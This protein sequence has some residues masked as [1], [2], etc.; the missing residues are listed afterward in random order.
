MMLGSR[1]SE[2]CCSPKD[3]DGVGSYFEELFAYGSAQEMRNAGWGG[4]VE[5]MQFLDPGVAFPIFGDSI[6]GYFIEGGD[7]SRRT[8]IQPLVNATI[9][10]E[11]D[12][13][14]WGFSPGGAYFGFTV[15]R[16]VPDESSFDGHSATVIFVN[17]SP[18]QPQQAQIESLDF[19]LRLVAEFKREM[20]VGQVNNEQWTV[21]AW[22]NDQHAMV[23]YV[24]PYAANWVYPDRPSIT[25]RAECFT[26]KLFWQ[27]RYG[28]SM[29]RYLM[30]LTYD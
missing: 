20:V 1:C 16:G 25:E 23:N 4:A 29:S 22:V 6:P 17:D 13:D 27:G 30:R 14:S 18:N 7:L 26:H 28:F 19:P 21:N 15:A 2:C 8:F 12:L 24:V 11:A 3:S 9:R 10:M 5:L